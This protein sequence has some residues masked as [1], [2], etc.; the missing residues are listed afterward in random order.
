MIP[1]PQP[2]HALVL[3]GH[4][5]RRGEGNDGITTLA[6]RLRAVHDG[7]VTQG[8]IELATPTAEAA[9]DAAVAA[10]ATDVVALPAV[11]LAAAHAKNDVPMAIARA[12]LKHPTVT[13][14][15]ARPLGV[16]HA[17]L[18]A[19]GDH[20]RAV[21]P[22]EV[23]PERTAVLL[24]GRGS[25]DPDAN[26]DLARIARLF[27]E[28]RGLLVVDVAYI[29]VT[30]PDPEAAFNTLLLRR[31]RAVVVLPWLLYPGILLE[32]LVARFAEMA[33]LH[34]RLSVTVAAPI[35]AHPAVEEVLLAR[36]EEARAGTGG[37][38][39]DA[40][41]YRAPIEGFA[42]DVGGVQALRKAR[43][44]VEL[45]TIAA[46]GTEPAAHSHTPPIRHVLVCVNRD[47]ADR[48]AVETLSALRRALR[49]AG[50]ARTV[51]TTRVMCLGRC[52]EGPV[53]VVYPDGVW[54]RR[55]TAADADEL[56]TSHLVGGAP[57]G[58][59]VDHLLG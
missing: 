59:L 27:A 42:K 45:P 5:S 57:V 51:R 31:P 4:G 10:G 6:E 50:A 11:L 33:A 30:T 53:V 7:P 12:R 19:L 47:C 14:T 40:C 43:A 26:A 18:A 48:G 13:F 49:D 58:R 46:D 37:P 15:A 23:E 28:R 41:K 32:R 29:G 44:H 16:H 38:A 1:S 56:T 52:G 3:L 55:V 34:P 17:L 22:A 21:A 25:S 8:Y 35:G 20:F 39:C 9:L 36:A 24:V 2:R 54:Y